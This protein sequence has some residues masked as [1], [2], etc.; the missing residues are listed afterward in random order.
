[1]VVRN[2]LLIA[3]FLL[4][5]AGCATPQPHRPYTATQVTYGEVVETRPMKIEGQSTQI[6]RWGGASIGRAIGYEQAGGG[7]WMVAGAV[8]GVAGAVAGEAVER[9]V[10]TQEGVEVTVRLDDGSVIAVLQEA[11]VAFAAGEKVRV[12]LGRDGSASISPL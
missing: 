3:P 12:L 2:L 8:A 7:G 5:A 9:K 10:R 1:M 4:L 6:G 11:A